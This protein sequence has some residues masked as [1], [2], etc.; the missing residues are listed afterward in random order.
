M[1]R[2]VGTEKEVAEAAVF[3]FLDTYMT[4]STLIP[5]GGYAWR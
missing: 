4:G 3:L 2:R 5:D 1:L